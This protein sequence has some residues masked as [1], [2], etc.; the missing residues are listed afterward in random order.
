MFVIFIVSLIY[1]S[2]NLDIEIIDKV[3]YITN[4]TSIPIKIYSINKKF[5]NKRI[6][7]QEFYEYK[8]KEKDIEEGLELVL[9]YCMLKFP[10]KLNLK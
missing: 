5:I 1:V 7:N 6:I 9:K 4:P 2:T 10:T 8:I 3:L